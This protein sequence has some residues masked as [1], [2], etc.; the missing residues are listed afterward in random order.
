MKNP[1][2]V[3]RRCTSLMHNDVVNPLAVGFESDP[4]GLFVDF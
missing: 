2:G 4:I 3:L 1:H